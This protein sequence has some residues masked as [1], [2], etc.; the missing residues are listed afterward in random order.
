MFTLL[1]AVA[2]QPDTSR[3][4]SWKFDCPSREFVRT[5]SPD[6]YSIGLIYYDYNKKPANNPGIVPV[7][8]DV[9]FSPRDNLTAYRFYLPAMSNRQLYYI[10]NE[11]RVVIERFL[12]SPYTRCSNR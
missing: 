4:F 10:L 3:N 7:L 8:I 12:N 11:K 6:Y 1:A 5:V 9:K 2:L